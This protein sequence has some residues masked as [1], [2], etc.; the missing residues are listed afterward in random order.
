MQQQLVVKCTNISLMALGHWE[1]NEVDK[2]RLLDTL[3]CDHLLKYRGHGTRTT[4]KRVKPW[5]PIFTDDQHILHMYTD[6]AQYGDLVSIY[7]AHSEEKR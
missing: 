7:K 2:N 1:N 6:F 3:Q 5:D 4:Q